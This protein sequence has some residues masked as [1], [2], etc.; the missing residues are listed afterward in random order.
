MKK[1]WVVINGFDQSCHGTLQWT[2]SEEWTDRIICF[3]HVDTDSE[4]LKA[5][6]NLQKS[7]EI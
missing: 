5:D 7:K 4:K 2:V 6:Q 3:L 1:V